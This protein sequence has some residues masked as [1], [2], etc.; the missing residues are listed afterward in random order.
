MKKPKIALWIKYH[1]HWVPSWL[2]SWAVSQME[3]WHIQ[4][5]RGL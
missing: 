2:W 5:R 4:R 3:L 1:P